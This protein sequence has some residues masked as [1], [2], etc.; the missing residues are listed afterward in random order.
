[1]I[2]ILKIIPWNTYRVH[3]PQL[4]RSAGSP[5][6]PLSFRC[7]SWRPAGLLVVSS[8]TRSFSW[9]WSSV[10]PWKASHSWSCALRAASLDYDGC[11]VVETSWSNATLNRMWKWVRGASSSRSFFSYFF[12]SIEPRWQ[13]MTTYEGLCPFWF[14][15]LFSLTLSPL[16]PAIFYEWSIFLALSYF[17][18]RSKPSAIPGLKWHTSTGLKPLWMCSW[19]CCTSGI[20]DWL[21]EMD[22]VSPKPHDFRQ[23]FSKVLLLP[24]KSRSP[25]ERADFIEAVFP[26]WMPSWCSDLSDNLRGL[27]WDEEADCWRTAGASLWFHL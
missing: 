20:K 18:H 3:S 11:S 25:L 2:I 12:C 15:S 6:C 26:W 21:F 10:A 23:P 14:I 5:Q 1:M 4:I 9:W 13:A 8:R 16:I 7:L 24:L 27:T 17:S 22:L 19:L